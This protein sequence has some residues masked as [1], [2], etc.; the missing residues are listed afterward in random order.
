M[1]G[2][3]GNSQSKS[4]Y[5]QRRGAG[6]YRAAWQLCLSYRLGP[7]SARLIFFGLS[8]EGS[9]IFD[10]FCFVFSSSDVRCWLWVAGKKGAGF[11]PVDILMAPW[12]YSCRGSLMW[13]KKNVAELCGTTLTSLLLDIPTHRWGVESIGRN[14]GTF[15]ETGRSGEGRYLGADSL[16]LVG[17]Q[18][19]HQLHNVP[20]AVQLLLPASSPTLLTI[21]GNNSI[22]ISLLEPYPYNN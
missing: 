8:G 22:H 2:N 1:E 20:L 4:S 7:E 13:K 11:V 21:S 5:Q 14:T 9:L 6:I 10:L 18:W 19:E 12:S 15:P 3:S 16:L 17:F